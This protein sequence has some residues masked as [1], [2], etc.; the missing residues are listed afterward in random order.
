M[1]LG[2]GSFIWTK[3]NIHIC[4]IT[5]TS[6]P[7]LLQIKLELF[8]HICSSNIIWCHQDQTM[9]SLEF[10][11]FTPHACL[12]LYLQHRFTGY[13]RCINVETLKNLDPGI[14]LFKPK[15]LIKVFTISSQFLRNGPKINNISVQNMTLQSSWENSNFVKLFKISAKKIY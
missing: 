9:P 10:W 15:W 3:G 4:K 8:S 11:H 5:N 13:S 2:K 6:L 14:S 7:Q 12:C 1:S